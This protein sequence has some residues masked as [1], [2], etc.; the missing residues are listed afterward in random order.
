[1]RL[2][3]NDFGCVPDGRVLERVTIA[4]GSAVLTSPD[5]GLRATD[6]GKNIA[7]PGA[8]DLTAKIASLADRTDVKNASMTAGCNRLTANFATPQ[9]ERFRPLHV[10]RRI[11]VLGAG[12]EASRC[13]PTWPSSSTRRP[14][15]SSMRPQH[16]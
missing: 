11:V 1:M 10:G 12:P 6:A 16:R 14:W 7:I 9:E 8:A 3:V 13:S 4:A 5:G 15:T 2:H